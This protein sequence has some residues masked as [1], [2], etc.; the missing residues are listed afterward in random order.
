MQVGRRC[1]NT[2]A[3]G[4][5]S[6]LHADETLSDGAAMSAETRVP[7]HPGVS[8]RE[9]GSYSTRVTDGKGRRRRVTGRTLSE[10]KA[11]AAAV[12]TDAWRGEIRHQSGARFT[13]YARA[14]IESYGGRTERGIREETR[15]EYR[16]SLERYAIPFF[17]GSS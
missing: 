5:E 12:K 16:N 3:R 14:W 11:N 2:P 1:A 10:V 17:T 6:D 13:E 4:K 9:D 15:N 8:R 7:G